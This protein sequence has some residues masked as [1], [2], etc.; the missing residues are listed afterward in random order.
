VRFEPLGP[1]RTR[2]R[3]TMAYEP[4]GVVENVGDAM[5]MFSAQVEHSVEE[6]KDFIENR[7]AETGGWRGEVND[8]QRVR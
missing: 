4:E 8:S 5:G 7:G 2:V 1:D 3:L 6:F